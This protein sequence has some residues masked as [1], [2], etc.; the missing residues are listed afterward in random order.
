MRDCLLFSPASWNLG[1]KLCHRE[2]F[3]TQESLAISPRPR[4]WIDETF[5]WSAS[6]LTILAIAASLTSAARWPAEP[7][8]TLSWSPRRAAPAHAAPLPRPSPPAAA[9]AFGEPVPGYPVVSPF[10]LRQLPWEEA[11]RLHKGVDIAAPM[12]SP[13]LAAADGRVTRTGVDAGYGRFVEVAH[14]GGMSSLYGHLSRW[15]AKPGAA[16]KQG[17]PIGLIGSTGSST[18][19]HLHFEVHGPRDQ[20]LNPEMFLGR[21]FARIADLPLKAA[22]RLPGRRVRVAFVSYIPPAKAAL[23]QARAEA[24]AAVQAAIAPVEPARLAVAPIPR[25]VLAAAPTPSSD[26][27]RVMG[28][29]GDGRV[30][31]VIAPGG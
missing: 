30:H 2:L 9:I 11:G 4:S 19:A 29:T 8:H 17:Q 20:A 16:V 27:L 10:G 13:V 26:G 1:G 22:A 7:S 31:A 24:K 18:G 23:M 14:A 21:S 12:G 25:V 6:S 15:E 3:L 28:S 5:L